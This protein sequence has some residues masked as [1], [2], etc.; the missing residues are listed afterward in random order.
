MGPSQHFDV[1]VKPSVKA[2]LL[3]MAVLM[4]LAFLEISQEGGFPRA[5]APLWQ[6]HI[7]EAVGLLFFPALL[8][9]SSRTLHIQP[10]E[11]QI[12]RFLGLN[13]KRYVEGFLDRVDFV[14]T[15]GWVGD[16]LKLHFRDGYTFSV[17]RRDATNWNQLVQYLGARNAIPL[18][19]V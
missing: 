12:T 17:W 15:N 6:T 3:L 8:V 10:P 14:P 2:L 1:R 4:C 9:H 11:I 19:I 7:F 16:R 13:R 5:T 18:S